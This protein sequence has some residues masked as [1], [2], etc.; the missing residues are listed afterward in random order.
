[1][2]KLPVLAPCVDRILFFATSLEAASMV[3]R[4]QATELPGTRMLRLNATG[5]PHPCRTH[6]GRGGLMG[7]IGRGQCY[8]T[9][10]I[11]KSGTTIWGFRPIHA[12]DLPVFHAATLGLI[13]I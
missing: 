6:T 3:R 9:S 4:G 8:T 12:E 2:P 11:S 1:M 10:E 5:E 7:A 13:D